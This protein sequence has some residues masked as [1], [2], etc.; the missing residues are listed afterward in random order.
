[1]KKVFTLLLS[2]F[3]LCTIVSAQ[4]ITPIQQGVRKS[5]MAYFMAT[6]THEGVDGQHLVYSQKLEDGPGKKE[7]SDYLFLI[8][9]NDNTMTQSIVAHHESFNFLRS[10]ENA[11]GLVAYYLVDDNKEKTYT[12]YSNVVNKEDKTHQW[13]PEKLLT[14]TYEKRDNLK[15]ATSVSP[16]KTK[17]MICFLQA[18]RKGQFKG[19]KIMTFDNQGNILWDI[20]PEFNMNNEYFGVIDMAID[21]D[22]TVYAGVYSY[23]EI[24]KNKRSDETFHIY[25]IT[26]ND[27]TSQ[28][29]NIGYSISNGKM[30]VGQTGKV[31]VGGY[32][33]SNLTKNE[34]GSY[35][36]T[37][38]PSS[39]SLK[40]GHQQFP[41]EYKDGNYP[42]GPMVGFYPNQKY[43]VV[44]KDLVEF[45][46]GTAAL[47]GEL[48]TY[49]TIQTQNGSTTYF[50]TKHVVYNQTNASGDVEKFKLFDRKAEAANYVSIT[51]STLFANDKIYVMFPDH[52]DNYAGKTGFPYKRLLGGTKKYCCSLL[53]IDNQGEGEMKKLFDAKQ[54]KIQVVRPL[55]VESD[56]F[57]VLD[58]DK[59]GTNFSKIN[60]EL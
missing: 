51:Y 59:K 34:D 21:N 24:S 45:S 43:G 22:G 40:V 13:D 47:L 46:N 10:F 26:S 9:A 42:G 3:C 49:V 37:Y 14:I 11:D 2:V 12:L 55:F 5:F 39:S 31:Y 23:D 38:D 57:I 1:M 16:D 48:R 28:S 8:N 36:A 4:T 54:S 6:R 18:Q 29:E 56:G 60:V 58:F 19:S 25:H 20:E 33:C 32:T 50:F 30:I 35:I 41:S 44:V 27:I 7:V 53:T 52:M 17:G 15:I